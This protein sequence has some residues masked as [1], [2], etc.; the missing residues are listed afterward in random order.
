LRGVV[1]VAV[2]ANGGLI[3]DAILPFEP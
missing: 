2:L 3:E 1:L